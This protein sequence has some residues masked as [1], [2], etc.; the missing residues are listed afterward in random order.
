M[1]SQSSFLSRF[2]TLDPDGEPRFQQLA[3][4]LVHP[5][6]FVD[7]LTIPSVIRPA[8]TAGEVAFMRMRMV[9]PTNSFH[10]DLP[11][12]RVDP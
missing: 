8:A 2:V 3:D 7:A 1:S 11:P 10:R 12:T 4:G 9:T 6:P 5:A